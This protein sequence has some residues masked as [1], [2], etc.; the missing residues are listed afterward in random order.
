MERP[1]MRDD[2]NCRGRATQLAERMLFS[3]LAASA[4]ASW[5]A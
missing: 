1:V 2:R 3:G 5:P 4:D